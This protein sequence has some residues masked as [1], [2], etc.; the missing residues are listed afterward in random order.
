MNK[1]A[2]H[3]VPARVLGKY[4]F[5]F[6]SNVNPETS[7]IRQPRARVIDRGRENWRNGFNSQQDSF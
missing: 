6:D 3:N 7:H 2:M 1:K 4:L 5:S